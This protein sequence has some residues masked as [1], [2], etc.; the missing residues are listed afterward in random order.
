VGIA[1]DVGNATDHPDADKQKAGDI[2]LGKGPVIVSGPNI[3]PVVRKGLVAAARKD[4]IAYQTLG[5]SRATGTDANAM[6]IS[7]AG[8][9]AGLVSVPNRY[10]HTP[11]EMISLDDLANTSKILATYLMTLGPRSDFTP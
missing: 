5:A 4:K 8:V 7:R 10:M 3:N 9:A 2:K 6:Q 11:V 1:V